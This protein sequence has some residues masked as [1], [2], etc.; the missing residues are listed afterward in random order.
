MESERTK[1]P[2]R[3][4]VWAGLATNVAMFPGLG[5]ILIGSKSGLVQ[6]LLTLVADLML[7]CVW[8]FW[9]ISKGVLDR[10]WSMGWGPH[11]RL[12]VLALILRAISWIWSVNTSI[13]MVRAGEKN[14]K[15]LPPLL[16]P[17][18]SSTNHFRE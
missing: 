13:R 2:D 8:L 16:S 14:S 6:A 5:S 7:F 3:A 18:E 17:H 15:A 12:V 4:T 9:Y 1:P 10:D 11:P